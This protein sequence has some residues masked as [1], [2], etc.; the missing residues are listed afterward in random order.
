VIHKITVL[1]LLTLTVVTIVLY[2]VYTEH[3]AQSIYRPLGRVAIAKLDTM[4][5]KWPAVDRLVVR[6][7]TLEARVTRIEDQVIA[8]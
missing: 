2:Y 6:V 4:Y 1:G 8:K 3:R 7:D 5:G